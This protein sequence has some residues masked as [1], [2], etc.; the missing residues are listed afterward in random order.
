M[1]TVINLAS[2][3]AAQNPVITMKD[4]AA[5]TGFSLTTVSQCMRD[6][7][8]RQ[9]KQSTV[10]TIRSAAQEMG[11]NPRVA[12]AYR[13][14]RNVPANPVFKSRDAETSAMQQLSKSGHSTAEVAH[15]CGVCKATVRKRIG[16][17][18]A[19][20]TAANR[21]LAGQV[22]SAKAKIKLAYKQKQAVQ[23]Y[24]VLAAKLNAHLLEAHKMQTELL[25]KQKSAVAAS[26][27]TKVPLMKILQYPTTIVS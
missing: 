17:Q 27:A 12:R 18:P 14:R 15:R 16:T 11:Y 7:V 20:I 1:A 10:D 24:N 3:N 8:P 6:K 13:D 5:K 2:A 9:Y 23:E 22:R 25:S 26:T 21:K 4:I 19:E